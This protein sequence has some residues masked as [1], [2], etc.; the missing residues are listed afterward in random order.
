MRIARPEALPML[1]RYLDVFASYDVVVSPP[2]SCA[3]MVRYHSPV[4]AEQYGD[5][6]RTLHFIVLEP[7]VKH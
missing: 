6:P 7:D 2:A 1:R 5:G 3:G 4:L